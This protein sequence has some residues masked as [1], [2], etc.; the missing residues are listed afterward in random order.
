VAELFEARKP[1]DTA[2][3]RRAIAARVELRQG[4]QGQAPH[5]VITPKTASEYEELDPEVA[6]TSTCYEGDR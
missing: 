2:D 5:L 4:D 1:K 3:P 6:S